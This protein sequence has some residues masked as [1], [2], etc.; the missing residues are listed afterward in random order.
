MQG[1]GNPIVGYEHKHVL[2]ECLGGPFGS[3]SGIIPS[4]VNLGQNY[5]EAFT[6]TLPNSY[7]PNNM[8]IVGLV[9][10]NG[11]SNADRDII[12]ADHAPFPQAVALE[13]TNALASF[14][15]VYPNPS[16]DISN[17][18]Y[19]LEKDGNILMEMMNVDG[20]VVKVLA[21]GFMN[22]GIHTETVNVSDLSAGIY[23]I[24]LSDEEG[25]AATKRV[26]IQ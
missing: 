26:L 3:N 25:Y 8:T 6:Y 10:K 1:Q 4:Q 5:S 18:T 7:D 20:K 14:M 21:N 15:K 24:R 23:L 11:A 12:N 16:S 19:E 22:S 2:R 9:M 13:E 17:V